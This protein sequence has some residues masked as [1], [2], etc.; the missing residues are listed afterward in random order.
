MEEPFIFLGYVFK[1][2]YFHSPSPKAIKKFKERVKG[3]TKRNLTVNI[4]EFIKTKLNPILRG[5]ARY[6]GIGFS[7]S[8]FRELDQWI[9]RRLRMIQLRS[10]RKIKKFHKQL[11]LQNWKGELPQLRMKSW[12]SSKSPPVSVAM[13][14]KWFRER[15][16]VFLLDI[17]DELHPQRG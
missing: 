6:F 15:K 5:W 11:R 2:G 8:L 12:R 9:R 13:P 17:Y 3:V 10:W 4:E 14:N 7:K 16:L 1:Q